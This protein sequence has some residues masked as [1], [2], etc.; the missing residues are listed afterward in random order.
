ML[1]QCQQ[2][3]CDAEAAAMSMCTAIWEKGLQHQLKLLQH[4]EKSCNTMA[5]QCQQKSCHAYKELQAITTSSV[6][7]QEL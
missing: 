4:H 3:N 5:L 7:L 6:L 1:L 2:K